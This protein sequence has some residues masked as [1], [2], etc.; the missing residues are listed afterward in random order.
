MPVDSGMNRAG[1]PAKSRSPASVPKFF[2]AVALWK[3]GLDALVQTTRSRS[4]ART[5]RV[6]HHRFKTWGCH[7]RDLP[8][9]GYGSRVV[10]L[11]LVSTRS[12]RRRSEE[13]SFSISLAR[14]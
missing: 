4:L 3:T 13:A 1:A 10:T 5:P 8:S 9:P 14:K 12:A 7:G 2:H 6:G 11:A